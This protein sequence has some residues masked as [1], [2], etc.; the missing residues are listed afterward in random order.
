MIT[1]LLCT[2]GT[3]L[4]INLRAVC[5]NNDTQKRYGIQQEQIDALKGPLQNGDVNS[6]ATIL[7]DCDPSAMICGAEVNS[8]TSMVEHGYCT[9]NVNLYFLH[10]ETSDG[11]MV[12]DILCAYYGK[13]AKSV[14]VIGLQEL[15]TRMF[16]TLGT[17]QPGE[18][19]VQ[20]HP[21]LRCSFLRHQR[22]GW[23]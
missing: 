15:D 1:N 13:R 14:I 7:L 20:Y 19:D 17:A 16:R 5:A 4:L 10:S 22:Y 11:Q 9:D 2:V 23:L 3:S 6:I 12:A 8:I 18:G 21:Q